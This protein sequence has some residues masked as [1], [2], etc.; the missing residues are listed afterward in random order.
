MA[1]RILL[2]G[3]KAGLDYVRN[4]I[5]A[6]RETLGQAV[7]VRTT[8][9]GGDIDRLVA[10]A[11]NEGVTRI[12]AGG[13]DG[14][15][16]EVVNALAKYALAERPEL[17]I[18][19]LGTA[20]DFASSCGI[21]TDVKDALV[22]AA[23]HPAHVVDMIQVNDRYFINVASAGFGAQVTVDTP[24]ELKNFLGG[25]A[26]T[27][28]GLIKALNFQ[29][30]SGTATYDGGILEGDLFVGAICNG[31]QAGGGQPLAPAAKINDGLMDVMAITGF[32]VAQAGQVIQELLGQVDTQEYVKRLRCQWLEYTGQQT[33]PVNLD[34]EPYN[35]KQL[36]FEVIPN[37]IQLVVDSG[38]SLIL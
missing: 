23:E 19:P 30:Y 26:Y 10:E 34:G 36:R 6:A 9:E 38:N 16:N 2:N 8:W 18:L 17:A 5:F 37:A 25:K 28:T 13:G 21:P 3:K 14:T 32:P 7:E 27:L 12:V 22:F 11:I 15:V 33:V 20:N 29:P 1:L 24:V 4:G 31:I 35:Q